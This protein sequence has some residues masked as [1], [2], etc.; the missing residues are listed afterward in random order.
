VNIRFA[1]VQADGNGW[2]EAGGGVHFQHQP[3]QGDGLIDPVAMFAEAEPLIAALHPVAAP[4]A[5]A[6]M[7]IG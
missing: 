7:A 3:N 2:V 4:G 6:A 5:A 1:Q